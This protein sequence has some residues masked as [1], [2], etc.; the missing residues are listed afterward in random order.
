[1]RPA[2]G[3]GPGRFQRTIPLQGGRSLRANYQGC[4]KTW[5][6]WLVNARKVGNVRVLDDEQLGA[7]NEASKYGGITVPGIIF[8]G[9]SPKSFLLRFSIL[10]SCVRQTSLKTRRRS[11]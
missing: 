1:M 5:A 11:V 10:G 7:E 8:F 6:A 9:L 4:S 2:T 3:G